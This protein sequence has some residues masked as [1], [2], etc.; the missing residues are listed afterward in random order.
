[1]RSPRIW[2]A[3]GVPAALAALA[4]LALA[5]PAATSTPAA[6]AQRVNRVA[7]S[8]VNAVVHIHPGLIKDCELIYSDDAGGYIA[9][10]GVDKP[11]TIEPKGNC[12]TLSHEFS[13]RVDDW[14][15]GTT[16]TATGWQ[17]QNGDGHCLRETNSDWDLELVGACSA[18]DTSEDFFGLPGSLK[19]F[20]AWVV[21]D[22]W[23]ESSMMGFRNSC[24]GDGYDVIMSPNA[25]CWLWSFPN[26]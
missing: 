3:L 25:E 18:S 13:V 5:V 6:T 7:A 15:T 20:G 26:G 1:M 21:S 19:A 14:V 23:D 11:V 12:F 8:H 17:Y 2:L 22:V 9:G 16:V 4:A 10:N 24:G